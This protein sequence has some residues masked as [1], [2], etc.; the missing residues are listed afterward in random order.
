M[1]LIIL[2]E[3]CRR[4]DALQNF[5]FLAADLIMREYRLQF[6]EGRNLTLAKITTITTTTK[7]E[8]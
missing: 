5:N 8:R 1:W 3:E 6:V 2:M 4:C 7:V